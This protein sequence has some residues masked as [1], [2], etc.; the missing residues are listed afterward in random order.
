MHI[1]I[2]ELTIYIPLMRSYTVEMTINID[3][4]LV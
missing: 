4:I 2:Y 1:Y 3:D